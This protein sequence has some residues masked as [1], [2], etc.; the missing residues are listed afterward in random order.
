MEEINFVLK[1]VVKITQTFLSC[2]K[3]S[4]VGNDELCYVVNRKTL[5]SSLHCHVDENKMICDFCENCEACMKLLEFRLELD[6]CYYYRPKTDACYQHT[7][8]LIYYL[9]DKSFMEIYGLRKGIDWS[10]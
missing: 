7:R 2:R 6:G 4:H 3:K 1:L 10:R 8:W 5:E 9:R